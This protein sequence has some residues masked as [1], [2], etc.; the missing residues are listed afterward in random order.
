MTKKKSEAGALIDDLVDIAERIK[1]GITWY[2]DQVRACLNQDER[3]VR[4]G[5]VLPPLPRPSAPWPSRQ[6]RGATSSQQRMLAE[7]GGL[8][9]LRP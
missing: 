7:W 1:E 5:S 2:S 4:R 9:Y 3:A 8:H 6:D